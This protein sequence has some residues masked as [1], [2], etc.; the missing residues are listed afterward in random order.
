MMVTKKCALKEEIKV[1]CNIT[2]RQH[3][4]TKTTC[5]YNPPGGG[6]KSNWTCPYKE[7]KTTRTYVTR[8]IRILS[9]VW[10]DGHTEDDVCRTIGTGMKGG[11]FDKDFTGGDKKISFCKEED[12]FLP[13]IFE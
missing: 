10:L 11:Y 3:K 12:P 4:K 9:P 2:T 6:N 5:T 8:G 7:G 13:Q 1:N